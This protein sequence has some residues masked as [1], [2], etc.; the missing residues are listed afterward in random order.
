MREACWPSRLESIAQARTKE[1]LERKLGELRHWQVPTAGPVAP[2]S[3]R[4][5]QGWV[6]EGHE[7]CTDLR[8]FASFSQVEPGKLQNAGM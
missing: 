1:E 4:V 3:S 6:T 5:V 7:D 2:S 8:V